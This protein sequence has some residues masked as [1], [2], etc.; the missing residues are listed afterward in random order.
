MLRYLVVFVTAILLIGCASVK[1][2]NVQN[3]NMRAKFVEITKSPRKTKKYTPSEK[4]ELYFSPRKGSGVSQI[5]YTAFEKNAPMEI[6]LQKGHSRSANSI[7]FSPDGRFLAATDNTNV[8]L[9]SKDGKIIR[10]LGHTDD[11]NSIVFHPNGRIIAS[12]GRERA[13]RLWGIDGELLHIFNTDAGIYSIAFSP[14]GK[15]IVGS[16]YTTI[17]LWDLKGRRIR[18]IKTGHIE[19]IHS[20]AVSPDGRFIISGSMD[21]TIKLWG[22]DGKLIKTFKG[23]ND[24]I[25]SVAFS[26]NGKL[27]ASGSMD[28][29]VRIWDLNG[30]V[31]K[32]TTAVGFIEAVAFSPDGTKLAF[33]GGTLGGTMIWDLSE[34]KPKKLVGNSGGKSLAFS[35]DNQTLA[36]GEHQEIRFFDYVERVERS[37]GMPVCPIYDI[38]VS[39][40]GSTIASCAQAGII[41]LWDNSGRL[42]RK[43][44]LN[45]YVES[46]AFSP[47]G[48]KIA[49][50]MNYVSWEKTR[51]VRLYTVDGKLLWQ[52]GGHEKNVNSIAFSP[53][54]LFVVSG[55]DDR[56]IKLW[57][58]D[59]KLLRTYKGHTKE[60]TGV[61]FSP[62]SRM[63]VSCSYDGTTRLWDLKGKLLKKL[64]VGGYVKET[65]FSHDGKKIALIDSGFLYVWSYDDKLLKSFNTENGTSVAF[66]SDDS[67]VAVGC[68]NGNIGLYDLKSGHVKVFKGHKNSIGG[69]ACTPDGKRLV[70]GGYDS[71][72]RVWNVETGD[73]I[74]LLSVGKEWI[75]YTP[76]GY[77][78]AS[79]Y[80]GKLVSMTKGMTTYGIDQFATRNNRPDILL[81]RTGMGNEQLVQHYRA[82]YEKR[83]KR[84]KLKKDFSGFDYHVPTAK[85]INERQRGKY[86]YIDFRLSDSKYMLKT[87][88]IYVNDIPIFGAYGKKISGNQV[89]KNERIELTNGKNKIEITAVN[90]AGVESYR[91]LL[92][93]DYK[94]KIKRDLYYLGFGVSKYKER[95]LNLKY[96]DK[97]AKDLAQVFSKMK[98]DFQNVHI[99]TFINEEVTIKNI[100]NA[101]NFLKNSRVDDVFVLF[102]AG[103]GIHDTDR[104]ATYYYLTH[105]AEINNLSETAAQFDLIE[106]LMQGVAPRNKLFLMDTCESGEVDESV[107]KTY[108]AM[109][110]KRGFKARTIRGL[111]HQKKKTGTLTRKN[112]PGLFVNDRFIYNDLIRRSGA[113]VFSSSRGGEFSY[114]SDT[115][116]NGFFT[117][118]IINAFTKNVAD[119]NRDK[120]ISTSELRNYVENA[121]PVQTAQQQHP[122]IDR[123]NIYQIF[124][125]PLVD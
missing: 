65:V 68:L 1:K 7:A 96:A 102:I 21:K 52:R 113:I 66:T 116:K 108:Y 58:I 40:D 99:K 26:P 79:K 12:A 75:A 88:N 24:Y 29:T 54:G 33:T 10:T 117:E 15:I 101:K 36:I 50:G 98:G 9:W 80:G 28:N 38:A 56:T 73:H 51:N 53:D 91:A 90:E 27:I 93:A 55:S 14:D 49:C 74:V 109:A 45:D 44:K 97:D 61:A 59:G 110:D 120:R 118:E 107:Q 124:G 72:I 13:V 18:T 103:H 22:I 43:I 89:N 81:G 39:P 23:H 77:F 69:I 63:I 100:I 30:R 76:D 123:D 8:H 6:V 67:A 46:I 83:L 94:E 70:T 32:K 4:A 31:L 95:T 16:S 11:V 5:D 82:V 3:V 105:N 25:R 106:E 78:D 20:I 114:E 92:Y 62:D 47:D 60:V 125:F 86:V 119:K 111:K 121:V 34:K 71:T 48:K 2:E 57:D 122:T 85:I 19:S 41:S 84:M 35:S 37:L 87:Y 112:R 115:I 42:F 64:D 17:I 104:E